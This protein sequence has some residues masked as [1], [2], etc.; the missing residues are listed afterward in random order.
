LHFD[1][2]EVVVK[3]AAFVVTT[4]LIA[5]SASAQT[6][7]SSQPAQAAQLPPVAPLGS[8]TSQPPPQTPPSQPPAS[9]TAPSQP[10]AVFRSGSALV[11]LN[12]SVQDASAKYVGGLHP[13]DFAVYEDG[14]RQDVRFFESTA[15]PVDLIVLIDSSSSMTDKMD[16]VHEAA[17]GFLKTLREGDRGAVVAFADS[18]TVLQ[19]LTADRTMLD[20]AVRAT[21]AHGATALNNAVYIS[22]KQFG[23]SARQD[24]EPR[25]QAIVVLSDGEDTSSLVSFDDVLG[26]ARRMGVNIY[27][28]ALQSRAAAAKESQQGTRRY[29]SESD[30]SMKTLA[31]ETG[32]QAY[33]PAPTD[34]KSVYGSIATDLANQY[35]IGYVPQ[36]GRADGRFRR[37]VVQLMRP[38][39]RTRTRPGYTADGAVART[40]SSLSPQ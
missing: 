16:L 4:V 37:V 34:L 22:L 7:Q 33:F 15:V 9:Q 10:P 2:A 21:H 11:A 12:V 13:E 1:L 30:Y 3:A 29:F 17:A 14:V 19:P 20:R 35:S 38:G 6:P 28:V 27:T 36:N 31:R 25:R 26:V 32:G 39:L 23:Q 18:V 8:D 40:G 24:A 5:G